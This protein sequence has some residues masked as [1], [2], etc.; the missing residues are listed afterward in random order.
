M[1]KLK[2][3]QTT[4]YRRRREK[5]HLNSIEHAKRNAEIRAAEQRRWREYE[6]KVRLERREKKEQ[7]QLLQNVLL[8][9]MFQLD[10]ERT[11]SLV[12][13]EKIHRIWKLFTGQDDF[14]F[15]THFPDVERLGGE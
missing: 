1:S 5:E 11:G 9:R 14:T 8:R 10:P 13:W 7:L 15:V 12:S 3:C 6:E 4:K 2:A